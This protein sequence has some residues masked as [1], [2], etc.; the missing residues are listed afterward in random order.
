M[1][2]RVFKV[3]GSFCASHPWEVIVATLTL[4]V[5]VLSV[6]T[7]VAI[8]TP[9]QEKAP[10][11]NSWRRNCPTGLEV[12]NIEQLLFFFCQGIILVFNVS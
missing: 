6:E 4:T 11:C 7:R 10:A 1:V 2:S 5:C 3:H 8:P 9:T 12:Q